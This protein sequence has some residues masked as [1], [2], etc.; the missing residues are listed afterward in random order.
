MLLRRGVGLAIGVFMF[1]LM[2]VGSDLSCVKHGQHQAPSLMRLG[3]AAHHDQ[4]HPE[5]G[6]PSC[7]VPTRSDCCRALTSCTSA[8]N[9][10]EPSR[11]EWPVND[12][13]G[14][15]TRIAGAPLARVDAPD[16]PP[17]KA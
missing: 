8:Y 2:L 7:E 15:Y 16:P 10:R 17:P 11:G 1:H 5:S 6:Q 14:P 4:G 3:V 12:A 9:L 13:T